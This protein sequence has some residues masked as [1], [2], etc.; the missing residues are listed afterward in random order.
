MARKVQLK[1]KNGQ[2]VYPVTSS[3]QVKMTSGGG[4][5]DE[6]LSKLEEQTLQR[7]TYN[8]VGSIG[9]NGK[10]AS[11]TWA[12]SDFIP[13]ESLVKCGKFVA[14]ASVLNVAY[15]READFD[16]FIS[17]ESLLQGEKTKDDLSYPEGTKFIVIS[18]NPD[19]NEL[20]AYLNSSY[21]IKQLKNVSNQHSSDIDSLKKGQELSLTKEKQKLTDEEK[22]QVKS[23]IGLI[24]VERNS[25]SNKGYIGKTG[26]VTNPSSTWVHSDFIPAESLVKCGKFVANASVLNVAYYR[27]ADFD[28]FISGESLLQ[29]EKTKDDLSYPEGTKFIVISTDSINSNT[30]YA[31]LMTDEIADGIKQNTEDIGHLKLA[32]QQNTEA[33]KNI[34]SLNAKGFLHFSFDDTIYTLKDIKDKGYSSIFDQPFFAVLKSLHDKFGAVF[35][36]YCFLDYKEDG[37]IVFSLE[38]FNEPKVGELKENSSWLKFGLHSKDGETNYASGTQE[39]AK[40]DYDRFI[41]QIVRITGSVESIDL[42]PRLQNFAGNLITCQT[43]RDAS[44]GIIGLLSADYSET[45]GEPNTDISQGYY[46][47]D[48]ATKFIAKKGKWFDLENQLWFFPSNLRLDNTVSA[49]ITTYMDKFL[50]IEKWGRASIIVMYAHE[51]QMFKNGS[52]NEDYTKRFEN[53]CQWAVDNGYSFDFPMNK[54]KG[55]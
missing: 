31:E 6:K 16:S 7:N 27:E 34:N 32:V 41:N 35:S 45:G 46:L 53:C 37:E 5:L 22:L 49:N 44:C 1:N 43:M 14:N 13:A 29:G 55:L 50:T 54:I 8:N 19:S 9:T 36:C 21:E 26:A 3:E 2:K 12:H 48:P 51:N 38:D 20:Y 4:N 24:S 11:N 23:N 30:L 28:S 42:C 33:L 40:T 25:Y 10:P 39:N 15:Y 47:T 17:G 52:L 18:T